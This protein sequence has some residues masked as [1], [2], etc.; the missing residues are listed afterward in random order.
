MTSPAQL[1]GEHGQRNTSPMIYRGLVCSLTQHL[2]MIVRVG[3]AHC[4]LQAG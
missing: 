3:R 1:T 2:V 4:S